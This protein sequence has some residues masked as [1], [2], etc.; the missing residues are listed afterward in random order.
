MKLLNLRLRE[1]TRL[2]ETLEPGFRPIRAPEL[3]MR[4][5]VTHGLGG[6]SLG[7]S[8]GD[9]EGWE[10]LPGPREKQSWAA[11]RSPPHLAASQS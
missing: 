8:A 9:L 1:R 2:N 5:P 4:H 7:L 11:G 6:H 3:S 10:L